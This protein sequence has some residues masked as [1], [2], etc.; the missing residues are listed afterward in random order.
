MFNFRTDLAIERNDIL[1]KNN[2]LEEIE[3]I[4]TEEE[5][6][7]ENIKVSR[8]KIINENGEQAIRKTKR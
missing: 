6:I 1:K 2:D 8:V 3:G 4:E 5:K 7:D